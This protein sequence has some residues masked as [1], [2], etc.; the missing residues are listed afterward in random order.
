MPTIECPIEGC[1]YRIPDVDP[2]VAVALIT[3]HT[4]THAIPQPVP[5]VAKAEKVKHPCMLRK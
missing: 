1:K 3:T 4:T 2:V 5:T